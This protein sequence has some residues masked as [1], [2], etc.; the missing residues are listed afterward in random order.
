MFNRAKKIKFHS[1]KTQFDVLK[2][3]PTSRSMPDW[4]KK[5][6]RVIDGTETVKTCVPFLD[7]L[8]V[9]YTIPLPADVFWNS[10]SKQFTST[11]KFQLNSDHMP[12]QTEQ[13]ILPDMYDPQPHKWINSWHVQTPPGYS[14]LF[15]HP[16]NRLDL[17][18]Y[19]FSGIV[20]T[21]KHKLVINFPFVLKKDFNGVIPAGTP[22]IQAIPFKRD[23]WESEVKDTGESY[24][25]AKTFEVFGPPFSWYKR[26]SWNKKK[27][28]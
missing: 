21:D 1:D 16:M 3:F 8:T 2:P 5:M 27:F 9:G 12:I 11:S 4:W 25:Y 19:S 22:M 18:F 20:D 10:E 7:S 15:I 24:R 6:P 13:V 17:P 23:D 14:T 26:L 28:G